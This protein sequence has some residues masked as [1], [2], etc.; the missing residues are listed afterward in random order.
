[1]SSASVKLATCFFTSTPLS[2]LTTTVGWTPWHSLMRTGRYGCWALMPGYAP[3]TN[4]LSD[5]DACGRRNLSSLIAGEMATMVTVCL[6]LSLRVFGPFPSSI[7]LS[8]LFSSV[9]HSSPTL[10]SCSPSFFFSPLQKCVFLSCA[11]PHFFRFGRRLQKGRAWRRSTPRARGVAFLA[12]L[13]IY[14]RLR[15]WTQGRERQG[16]S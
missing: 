10:H 4:V 16:R 5:D 3:R 12:H 14:R 2:S 1:M 11:F 15:W 13:D 8:L 7:A 6:L 9:T